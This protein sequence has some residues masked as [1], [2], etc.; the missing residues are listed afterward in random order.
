MPTS[1]RL[2]WGYGTGIKWH[3]GNWKKEDKWILWLEIK[4]HIHAL[5]MI[6]KDAH[7]SQRYNSAILTW[8]KWELM[9]APMIEMAEFGI[10]YTEGFMEYKWYTD[11]GKLL[12]QGRHK[13]RVSK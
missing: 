1:I 10:Q 5:S 9:N 2:V 11:D 4:Q 13:Y 7:G 12:W 6:Y 8:L 3:Y